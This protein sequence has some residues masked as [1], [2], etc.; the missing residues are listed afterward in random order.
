[1]ANIL[2][3][4]FSGAIKKDEIPIFYESFMQALKEN[5][6]NVKYISS[7]NFLKKAWNG[8]NTLKE[9]I[10]KEKLVADIEDFSPSLC[11]AFNNSIPE[12]IAKKLECPIILWHADSFDYFN[13]KEEIKKNCNRYYY[14][15]PFERDVLVIKKELNISDKQILKITPA[16]AIHKEDLDFIQNISFIGT[17]FQVWDA[18]SKLKNLPNLGKLAKIIKEVERNPLLDYNELLKE[19]SCES[20]E[21]NITKTDCLNFSSTQNRI[22]TLSMLSDLG[23]KLYG[24]GEY[25][26]WLDI[27]KYLPFLAMCH[28][29]KDVY[30]LKH[31]QDIYNSSKISIN[32]S[33]T[34]A[35]DGFPWRVFDIMASN[36]CL[37]S[38]KRDGL[39]KFTKGYIDIPVYEN[40]YEARQICQKLLK[41]ENW[42]KEITIGSQ[43]CIEEKGRWHH[44]FKEIE[45]R[46]DVKLIN[47]DNKFLKYFNKN[48]TSQLTEIKY[49]MYIKNL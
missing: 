46:I 15:C 38:D 31:N 13:N 48:N 25:F 42:R 36:S 47:N 49:Q 5:G 24:K 21:K 20:I 45:K 34:Q 14:I 18:P 11:I 41:D 27:S 33:H 44:K 3:S 30:T 16:T 35:I 40:S 39:S 22:Q 6:N 4:F 37:V 9:N 8:N 1:M 7:H 28:D 23:L 26:D 2:I 32:I 19:T 29:D 17:M 43:K 12:N 10:D